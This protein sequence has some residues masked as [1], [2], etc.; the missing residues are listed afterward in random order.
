MTSAI[1]S[2]SESFSGSASAESPTKKRNRNYKELTENINLLV[3]E[4]KN[5]MDLGDKAGVEDADAQL[6]D[7]RKK[8]KELS[9][10]RGTASNL[11]GLFN[12]QN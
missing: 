7:L 1:K 2:I 6:K 12:A 3:Q 5:C 11:T 9:E 10:A 8:R 4:K